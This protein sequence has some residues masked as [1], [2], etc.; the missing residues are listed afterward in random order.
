MQ[1][2]TIWSEP[3]IVHGR[4]FLSRFAPRD[5]ET[6]RAKRT[7]MAKKLPKLKFWKDRG[8]RSVLMLENRDVSLSNHVA[9]L[10]A[11]ED[12]LA[13][14][15]DEPDEVWLVDTAINSEWTAWCLIRD[16]V[17][18]PDEDTEYRYWHFQPDSLETV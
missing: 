17:S 9:I 10:E 4:L 16:G 8:A 15:N 6:L 7:A 12:A 11:A 18:F 3:A 5:Y 14:R 13:G 2:E 1:R